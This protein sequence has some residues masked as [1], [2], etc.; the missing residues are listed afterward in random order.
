M[1]LFGD[2]LRPVFPFVPSGY[3]QRC[4]CNMFR[5]APNSYTEH[6]NTKQECYTITFNQSLN[7]YTLLYVSDV[8]RKIFINQQTLF[9]INN[10]SRNNDFLHFNVNE[11]IVNSC[12]YKMLLLCSEM[13]HLSFY[14]TILWS[15]TMAICLSF[16]LDTRYTTDTI[17]K[18]SDPLSSA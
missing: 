17:S 15:S 9:R 3:R 12:S 7:L 8:S 13:E 11:K 4:V 6:P 10:F 18:R 16:E 1:K 2:Q 14:S 5:S